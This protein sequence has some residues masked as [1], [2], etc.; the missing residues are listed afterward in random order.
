MVEDLFNAAIVNEEGIIEN[1][2][3]FDN[4]ETMKEFGALRLAKG[5]GIGDKYVTPEEYVVDE[6]NREIRNLILNI[7]NDI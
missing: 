1:I 3:V 4:E 6:Q 2:L 7:I 5:Q